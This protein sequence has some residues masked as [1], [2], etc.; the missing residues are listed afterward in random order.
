MLQRGKFGIKIVMDS[1]GG[2]INPHNSWLEFDNNLLIS[3]CKHIQSNC[4]TTGG[5]GPH[6]LSHLQCH[7]PMITVM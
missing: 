5:G 3:I 7:Q 2:V 6:H 1:L 4:P